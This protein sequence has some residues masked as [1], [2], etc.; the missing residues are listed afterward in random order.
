MVKLITSGKRPILFITQIQ[1]NGIRT[2]ELTY[3][4]FDHWLWLH[5]RCVA[6]QHHIQ[7][8]EVEDLYFQCDIPHIISGIFRR[9]VETQVSTTEALKIAF[10]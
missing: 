10:P 7:R 2:T 3:E 5:L 1:R 8:E 6:G 4:T 9:L